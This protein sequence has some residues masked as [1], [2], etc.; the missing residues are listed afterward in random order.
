MRTFEDFQRAISHLRQ[1]GLRLPYG[2]VPGETP[3]GN[4]LELT[5]AAW[6][7]YVWGGPGDPTGPEYMAP[8]TVIS[9]GRWKGPF[10]IGAPVDK[11]ASA[12]WNEVAYRRIAPN[13]APTVPYTSDAGSAPAG[14]SMEEPTRFPA[15]IL[16][17]VVTRVSASQGYPDPDLDAS[18]KPAWAALVVAEA[19]ARLIDTRITLLRA[20]DAE[21][22]RRI[23]TAYGAVTV[24]EEILFRLRA[25]A[26]VLAP[27][28][29][30]RDRLAARANVLRGSIRAAA[31]QDALDAIDP[32][33]DAHWAAPS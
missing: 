29:V 27:L 23:C 8:G 19:T 12:P 31:A 1:S 3:G 2:F 22:E 30:E 25:A 21:E 10:E 14:W 15:W 7:A 16:A 26:A 17:R 11:A 6:N 5:E 18:P 9:V 24:Q 4:L 33:R 32:A 28:D 13:L 20:V